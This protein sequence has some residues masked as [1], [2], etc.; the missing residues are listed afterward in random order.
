MLTEAA[1]RN[2]KPRQK[3]YKLF[4]ERGLFVLVVP[5]GGRLWRFRYRHGGKEK[6]LSLGAYPDVALRRAREKRDEARRL[7]ADGVDP[8]ARRP[9]DKAALGNTFEV[10]AREWLELVKDS[11]KE[12]TFERERSQ[13]ERFVF[14]E[15]G[16]RPASLLT[17]PEIL[18]VL[19]KIEVRGISDTAHRVRSTCLR[20]L[21]YAA[22]TG[23]PNNVN[24]DDL[25]G[26]LA[27]VVL[28]RDCRAAAGG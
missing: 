16:D 6:L 15:L 28:S 11:I 2:A 23:R 19:K 20:V 25:K 13:L 26:A 8:S 5:T 14:P 12:S 7:V 27:P 1:I 3:P 4:D 22:R 21:R 10:V 9:A 17:T 24:S 18:G